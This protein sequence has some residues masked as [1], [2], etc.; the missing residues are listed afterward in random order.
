MKIIDVAE[1]YTDQGGG[2]K[3]YINHKLEAASRLGHE[4]IIVAPGRDSM[5]EKRHGGRVIWIKGPRL[6]LDPRYVILWNKKAVHKILDRE[7]PDIVEGSS[8]W[9][10][11]NFV[12]SWKGDAV[13]TLIFHQDPVAVYPQTCFGNFMSFNSI[14]RLFSFFWNYLERL[15]NR[16][17][18]TVVSGEWLKQR[19]QFF[20][21]NNPIAVPFGVDKEF[22]SPDRRDLSLRS[23]LL[24]P[25]GLNGDAHLMICVSRFHPEKRLSTVIDGF[26]EASK[27]KKMGLI[28]FGDGPIE[29]WI[30]WKTKDVQNIKLMG[31][32][33]NRD[34][35]ADIMASSDYYV[36]GSAAETFGLVVAEAICS[37]LPIV[38]PDTG[39]AVDMAIP[40]FSEV[41][42]AGDEDSL[43]QALLAITDRNR[44]ELKSNCND[45]VTHSIHTIDEHFKHLFSLY[46]HLVEQKKSKVKAL[47][48]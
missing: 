45:A 46:Q 13:K 37:G 4:M 21:I 23:S 17:D 25:L 27:K 1:F 30:E 35:L 15:S 14:D 39:G 19:L 43:A 18:S 2:V 28:V 22:F 48:G 40:D 31:F 20:G 5:E 26:K 11:G 3:T 36:H 29:K 44:N 12:G 9:T 7:A 33:S 38:V 24:A 8:V 16:Y 34:E 6:P 10:G 41:Y 32:T 42:K 47:S